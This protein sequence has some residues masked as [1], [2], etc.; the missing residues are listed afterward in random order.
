M[1]EKKSL[2]LSPKTT[3]ANVRISYQTNKVVKY[4]STHQGTMLDC[5]KVTGIERANICRY[6]AEL[7]AKGRLEKLYRGVDHT[8]QAKAYY[9]GVTEEKK[10]GALC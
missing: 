9:Y 2:S 6:V 10:G 8:T 7:I 4:F 1:K 5:A 3:N